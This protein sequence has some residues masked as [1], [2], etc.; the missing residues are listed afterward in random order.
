MGSSNPGD[1]SDVDEDIPQL[2]VKPDELQQ[3]LGSKN[4]FVPVETAEG[5]G[6]ES[7]KAKA[8]PLRAEYARAAAR[9]EMLWSTAGRESAS[10]SLRQCP[11][12]GELYGEQMQE[13]MKARSADADDDEEVRPF[14]GKTAAQAEAADGT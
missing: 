12:A 11:I 4:L 14:A 13:Y 5:A 6:G 3:I 7:E 2:E 10:A 8:K 1:R 9:S